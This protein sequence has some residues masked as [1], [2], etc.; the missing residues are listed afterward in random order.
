MKLGVSVTT[1]RPAPRPL[2]NNQTWIS[3]PLTY[4]LDGAGLPAVEHQ[5]RSR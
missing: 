1:L 3:G 2:F 4:S 5:L